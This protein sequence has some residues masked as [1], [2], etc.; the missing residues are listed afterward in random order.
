MA[1]KDK[2]RI[3]LNKVSHS[4]FVVCNFVYYILC[5]SSLI[6]YALFQQ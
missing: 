2:L 1:D 4:F 6:I 3:L 5:E